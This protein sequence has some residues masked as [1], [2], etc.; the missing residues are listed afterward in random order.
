MT[1]IQIT[2]KSSRQQNTFAS[3]WHTWHRATMYYT[4]LKKR[5]LMHVFMTY[6]QQNSLISWFFSYRMLSS[7][8]HSTHVWDFCYDHVTVW[9]K[10]AGQRSDRQ[11]RTGGLQACMNT[12]LV[13]TRN[14]PSVVFLLK[15]PATP[16][17]ILKT[18]TS[19]KSMS[20]KVSPAFFR[21]S[22]IAGTGPIWKIAC[23][24]RKMKNK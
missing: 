22:V 17:S 15:T 3:F 23:I 24:V 10:Q 5:V 12:Y 14:T 6:S 13:V 19:T 11:A 4:L 20:F 16:L 8:F 7:H 1:Y 21:T 9:L 2:Y 18:L